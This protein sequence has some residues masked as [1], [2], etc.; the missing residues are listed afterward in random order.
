MDCFLRDPYVPVSSCPDRGGNFTW[1]RSSFSG[2]ADGNN[3]V[4]I[5]SL[6]TRIA[7][8]DSKRTA[9]GTLSFTAAA[10]ADFV[11]SLRTPDTPARR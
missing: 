2:G 3:C 6:P 8:R 7:I 9:H 11:A 10:F 4:E 1:R 5:A